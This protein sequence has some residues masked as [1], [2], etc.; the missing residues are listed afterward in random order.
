MDKIL[1]LREVLD[2]TGLSR[3]TVYRQLSKSEFPPPIKLGVKAVGW[4]LKDIQAWLA[5]RPTAG[6]A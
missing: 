2:S 4:Y 1:R 6:A 3:S 5:S